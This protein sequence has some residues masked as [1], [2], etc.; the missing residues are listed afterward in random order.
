MRCDKCVTAGA[1]RLYGT[2][3]DGK[4]CPPSSGG[5]PSAAAAGWLGPGL[6]RGLLWA[7]SPDLSR[8]HH[9]AP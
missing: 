5:P 6:H 1:L 2:R 4:N 7:A 8:C 9:A 3:C